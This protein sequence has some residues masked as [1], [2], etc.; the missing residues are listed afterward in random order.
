[1]QYWGVW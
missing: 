1:M